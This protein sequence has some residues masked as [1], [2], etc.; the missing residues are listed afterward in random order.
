MAGLPA[1][2]GLVSVY[3]W[4]EKK[5]TLNWHAYTVVF[6]TPSAYVVVGTVLLSGV[7]VMKPAGMETF[8]PAYAT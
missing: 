4:P 1:V 7:K 6:Q 2:I 8:V 5:T 3:S